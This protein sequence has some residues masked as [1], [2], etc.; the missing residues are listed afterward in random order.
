M[1]SSGI[2]LIKNSK[3]KTSKIV[4][5]VK[6][7][8]CVLPSIGAHIISFCDMSDIDLAEKSTHFGHNA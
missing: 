2:S 3:V 6:S 7:K 4:Q 5:I 1:K 8:L